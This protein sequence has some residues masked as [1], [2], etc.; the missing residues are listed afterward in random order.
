MLSTTAAALDMVILTDRTGSMQ[1]CLDG[2]KQACVDAVRA[3]VE[4]H[5]ANV[6]LAIVAPYEP[7]ENCHFY[8]MRTGFFEDDAQAARANDTAPQIKYMKHMK[9]KINI[10][11]M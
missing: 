10:R 1:P 9:K 4:T 8:N 11:R 3:V 6:R 2:C 5:P 7:E